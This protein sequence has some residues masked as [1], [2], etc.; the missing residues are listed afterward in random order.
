MVYDEAIGKTVL[1][2]GRQ[3]GDFSLQGDTWTW[4]GQLW[5]QAATTGPS[6]RELMAMAYDSVRHRVVLFGGTGGGAL[7]D[8]WEWD[9][10][11]WS[12]RSTFG[13]P[14]RW[15]H[16]MVYDSGTNRVFMFGGNNGGVLN[17]TWEWDGSLWTQWQPA[18]SPGVR[19]LQAMAY[20]SSR[21]RSVMFCGYP[22]SQS[23]DTWEL[24]GAG[25]PAISFQPQPVA[26]YPGQRAVFAVTASGPGG[27]GTVTYQWRRNGFNLT[28]GLRIAG[29][30]SPFLTVDNVLSSD[31][32][33]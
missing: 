17:D 27:G 26:V 12:Q 30:L 28:N 6:A 7:G 10:S 32:G 22:A 4:D 8:T 15:G 24:Q 23:N 20:D 29:A 16:S 9:G 21:A 33:Q 11:S 25:A 3:F 14:P 13:A 1:F 2:G 5:V 19:Y 18:T 31:A